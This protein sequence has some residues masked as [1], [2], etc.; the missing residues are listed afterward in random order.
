MDEL[1]KRSLLHLEKEEEKLR[2]K[3]TLELE[4]ELERIIKDEAKTK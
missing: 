1:I 4:D 2:S 3:S